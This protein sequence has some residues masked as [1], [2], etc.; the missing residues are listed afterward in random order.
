MFIFEGYLPCESP[1][2]SETPT[3][4]SPLTPTSSCQSDA[5][6]D[7]G[8]EV[9][10]DDGVEDDTTSGLYTEAGSQTSPS[11]AIDRLFIQLDAD[12]I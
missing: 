10:V 6:V 7:G 5:G 1:T 3:F 4:A 2:S 8:A 11:T 12:T 9:G